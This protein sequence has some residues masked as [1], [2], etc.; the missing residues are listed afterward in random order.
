MDYITIIMGT[1]LDNKVVN[2]LIIVA[3][4]ISWGII[5]G[6]TINFDQKHYIQVVA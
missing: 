2:R 5:E 6:G 1:N 4:N 3:Y